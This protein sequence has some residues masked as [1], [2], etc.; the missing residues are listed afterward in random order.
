MVEKVYY[1]TFDHFPSSVKRNV[2]RLS[3]AAAAQ[4]GVSKSCEARKPVLAKH[5]RTMT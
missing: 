3:Q 5:D 4:M 1:A 2:Q